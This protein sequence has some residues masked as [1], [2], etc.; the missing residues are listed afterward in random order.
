MRFANPVSH[1]CRLWLSVAGL[2][3][4]VLA[5]V[6][7][8]AEAVVR[9]EAGVLENPVRVGEPVVFGGSFVI[10]GVPAEQ[11]AGWPARVRWRI[12]RLPGNRPLAQGEVRIDRLRLPFA[13]QVRAEQPGSYRLE[14]RP[15]VAG[16]GYHY[17][18][19]G[20]LRVEVRAAVPGRLPVVRFRPAAVPATLESDREVHF[21][22]V[23]EI[24]APGLLERL[25]KQRL[26]VR[27]K[28]VRE[29][30]GAIAGSGRVRLAGE[31]T[32]LLVSVHPPGPGRYRLMLEAPPGAPYRLLLPGTLPERTLGGK[33][34][35]P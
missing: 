18:L 25:R 28:V 20:A 14:L 17:R 27:W 22:G 19:P 16:D 33:G 7:G 15:A 12:L 30:D 24:E 21:G 29:T 1:L 3:L 8:R 13:A 26:F 35:Q 32:L 5:P 9:F 4:L 34:G 11:V 23:L 6:T 10:E 2:L 31:R